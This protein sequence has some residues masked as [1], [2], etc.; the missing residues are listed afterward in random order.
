[1]KDSLLFNY[2]LP[3]SLTGNPCVVLPVGV[4]KEGLPIGAQIVARHWREDFAL[5]VAL[6]LERAMQAQCRPSF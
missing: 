4:S 1:M 6:A 2:T 3:Y 5:A